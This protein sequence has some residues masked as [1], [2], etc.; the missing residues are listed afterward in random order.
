MQ[1]DVE[2]LVR[3]I[4]RSWLDGRPREMRSML[5]PDVVM[6]FP[7]FVGR[8]S[9][10]DAMIAGFEEF[11][12]SA[13]VLS[14]DESNFEVDVV[15]GTAVVTYSFS[16][17]YERSDRRYLSTGRD[18]WIFGRVNDEWK[19]TWRTMLNLHDEEM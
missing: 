3:R 9:G 8:T 17:T 12:A 10:A 18:F 6:V 11:G 2:K 4:N 1:H 7:G 16:V 15:G 5:H 13:E 19:A 14:F